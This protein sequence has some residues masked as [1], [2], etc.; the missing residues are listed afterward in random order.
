MEKLTEKERKEILEVGSSAILRNDL[1][2]L[3]KGGSNFLTDDNGE[4][5][6]D[7]LNSFLTQYN[8]FIGHKRKPFEKIQDKKYLL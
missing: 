6:L 2:R 3:K 1:R 8:A 7:L 4:V 5:N